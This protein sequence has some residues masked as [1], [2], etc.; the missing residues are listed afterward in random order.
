MHK[1]K[2]I[3]YLLIS[4]LFVFGQ[5]QLQG[6]NQKNFSF[7]I[8]GDRTGSAEPE[9]FEQ[10]IKTTIKLNPDFV[11]NIGDLIEGYASDIDSINAQWDSIFSNLGYLKDK[12]YFTPGNHDIWDDQSEIIYLTRLGY[13]N[14]YYTFSI[15]KNHFIVLDNSRQ[16]KINDLDSAQIKWLNTTLNKFKKTDNIFCFMHRSF[17]KDAYNTNKPDTFHKLFVKYGVDYV[18]SGHDHFYCQLNWDGITYTQLGPSGS[19]YKVYREKEFGAFQ[20]FLV[21]SVK[22]N[23]PTIK[24]IEP[25]GTELAPDIVTMADIKELVKIDKSVLISA[26]NPN[27]A[28]SIRVEIK[29]ILEIPISTQCQWS[30]NN[31][32]WQII[33][34]QHSVMIAPQ[35]IYT[36]RYYVSLKSDSIYPLPNFQMTYPYAAGK[37]DYNLSRMVPTALDAECHLVN[38]IIKIDGNLT[39]KAWKAKKPISVFGSS[40]GKLSPTD[41]WQCWFAYDKDYIYISARLIDSLPDKISLTITKR[42][43]RVN[44]DDH[45]NVILQPNV[46]SDTYYQFFIN[47]NGAIWDRIC[48]QQGKEQKRDTKWNSNIIAKTKIIKDS[49]FSGWV[50]EAAIPFKDFN[51]TKPNQVWGFNLV[52][53]QKRKETVSI[54]SV[55]FEHDPKTFARLNFIK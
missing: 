2:S 39:E 17:W 16:A 32:A 43:D 14:P 27:Q 8:L 36:Y 48:Y 28:D 18:F 40:E 21:V 25:D 33:P 6:I 26:I 22:K 34:N 19:R 4:P 49:K 51:I 12:F 38:E 5:I 24:V 52:R 42:D 53:Y 9:I 1:I 55:P 31:N 13:K 41:P 37:K 23:K 10:I 29:N 47:A 3:V 11:M 35:N 7:A 15:G 54:Y 46:A 20:N 30:I 45:I 50:V 44:A